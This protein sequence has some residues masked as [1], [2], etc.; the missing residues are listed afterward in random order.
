MARP[1][2]AG[3]LARRLEAWYV[4]RS[5]NP[6]PTPLSLD[7]L[8]EWPPD[9]LWEPDLLIATLLPLVAAVAAIALL[10]L[11]GG[12]ARAGAMAGAGVAAGFVLAYAAVVRSRG[13]PELSE[14]LP[15]L[16]ALFGLVAGVLIDSEGWG[17]K[18]H[19]L[20]VIGVGLAA[21]LWSLAD[22]VASTDLGPERN[23]LVAC[24]AGATLVVVRA[25]RVAGSAGTVPVQMMVAAFGVAA[26]AWVAGADQVSALAIALGASTLGFVGWNWPTVRFAPG[27]AL[28]LGAG[29]PLLALAGVLLIEEDG[30]M[31]ALG[32]LLLVFFSEWI[33]AQIGASGKGRSIVLAFAS[34]LVVA[35]AVLVA[36]WQAGLGLPFLGG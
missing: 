20:L 12:K 4:P 11:I 33:A 13:L 30:S 3:Q 15:L 7:R 23:V 18:R 36:H 9:W 1:K 25:T 31:A 34:L 29:L 27:A 32:V 2:A 6:P 28:V 5:P 16:L 14:H 19:R 10:R 21:I 35:V 22:D 17:G 24:F 8:L 26:V